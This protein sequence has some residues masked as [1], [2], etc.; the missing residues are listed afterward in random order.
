MLPISDGSMPT[1]SSETESTAR[2]SGSR[3]V[4]R[5]DRPL[6]GARLAGVE[7]DVQHDLLQLVGGTDDVLHLRGEVHREGQLLPS[8]GETEHLDRLPGDAVEVGVGVAPRPRGRVDADAPDDGGDAVGLALDPRNGVQLVALL[9]HRLEVVH[10][11]QDRAQRIVDLV[12]HAGGQDAQ[13]RHPVGHRSCGPRIA[14]RRSRP[15]GR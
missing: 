1:P 6:L 9:L 15:P 13:R 3:E 10:V 12:R 7:E 5:R 8:Q 4:R 14:R 11:G 2:P